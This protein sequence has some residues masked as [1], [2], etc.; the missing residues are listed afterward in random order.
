MYVVSVPIAT[1]A[2]KAIGKGI[3]IIL[4]ID[5]IFDVENSPALYSLLEG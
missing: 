3:Y 5:Y 1:P 4:F 2:I